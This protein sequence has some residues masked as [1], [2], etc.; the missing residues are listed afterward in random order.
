MAMNTSP[1]N[2]NLDDELVRRAR[3]IHALACAGV[4]TRTHARLAAARRDALSAARA[5]AHRRMWLPA[6]GAMAACALALGVILWRPAPAPSPAH[7]HQAASANAE[8]PLEADSKQ[9]DLYQNL[10]FYQWL[11]QQPEMGT[12]A[13]GAAQ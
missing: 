9:M 1:D 3:E 10:D 2:L 11:A 8:L 13:D 4:D 12:S 6:A 7:A 5:P